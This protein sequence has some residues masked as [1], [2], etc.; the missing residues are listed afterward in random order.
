MIELMRPR[1]PGDRPV[2]R[3]V[4]RGAARRV[5]PG[6]ATEW[7]HKRLGIA[8]QL[9]DVY[10]IDPPSAGLSHISHEHFAIERV[11]DQFFL[12]D[13]GS[14][15][16]TIVAGKQ[17]GGDRSGGRTGLQHGDLIVVG[18]SGSPYMFRFEISTD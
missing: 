16:G 6:R 13:R 9:N 15:N 10:L 17:V 2:P 11:D 18:T 7:K 1:E 8:P 5:P 14:T 3:A 12:V 4:R